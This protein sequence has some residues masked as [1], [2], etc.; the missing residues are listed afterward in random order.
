MNRRDCRPSPA[1]VS[2]SPATGLC[3]ESGQHRCRPG[4]WTV[5]DTEAQNRVFEAVELAVG[6]AVHLPGELGGGVDVVRLRQRG[7]FVDQAISVRVAV[8]PDGARVDHPVD[9]FE[10]GCFEH[11]AGAVPV[12]ERGA[13]GV[14]EHGVDIG[15][16]REV[17]DRIASIQS[18]PQCVEVEQVADNGI[19]LVGIMVSRG[20]QVEDAR[21]VPVGEQAVHNVGP[22]E[23][24]PARHEDLHAGTPWFDSDT[25]DGR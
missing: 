18:G 15:Q 4:A 8:H 22:D 25:A 14:G 7:V 13:R 16:R 20:H 2:G 12:V 3:D 21:L 5:G 17:C 10:A 11:S 6:V 9:A 1:I 23:S 24:R 19:D